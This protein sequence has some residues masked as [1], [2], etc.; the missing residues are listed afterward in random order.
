MKHR[1]CKAH[2]RLE[3]EQQLPFTGTEANPENEDRNVFIYRTFYSLEQHFLHQEKT[4]YLLIQ[5]SFQK[6]SH[7]KLLSLSVKQVAEVGGN[8]TVEN[9]TKKRRLGGF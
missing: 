9:I 3:Y 8:I 4:Q 5:F 7:L 2:A 1:V 6:A